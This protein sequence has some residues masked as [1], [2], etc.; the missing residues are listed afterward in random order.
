ME[1][2]QNLVI[3]ARHI[4]VDVVEVEVVKQSGCWCSRRGL[5][6]H[7]LDF[8]AFYLVGGL[9]QTLNTWLAGDLP[10]TREELIDQ[11]IEV[12]VLLGDDLA[13]RYR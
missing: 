11:I 6:R 5:Y 3:P 9:V 7:G 8:R 2:V 1:S 12:F 4:V 10:M 13:D